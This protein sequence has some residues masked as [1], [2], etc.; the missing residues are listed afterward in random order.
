MRRTAFVALCAA[1]SLSLGGCVLS[2]GHDEEMDD[3]GNRR[4][5][6]LE[7]RMDAVDR[8]LESR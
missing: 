1:A 5:V 4:L 7:Q 8:A 6:Q 3:L 2:L